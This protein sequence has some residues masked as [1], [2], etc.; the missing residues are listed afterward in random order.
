[1]LDGRDVVG[2]QGALGVVLVVPGEHQRTSIRRM[3]DAQRVTNLVCGHGQQVRAC[4]IQL[5]SHRKS[6][7]TAT[8]C[9]PQHL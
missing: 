8:Q 7:Y 6:V 1:V 3:T 4:S 5:E 2:V 9:W